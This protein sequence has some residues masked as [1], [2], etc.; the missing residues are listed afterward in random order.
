ME[1]RLLTNSDYPQ[2]IPSKASTV[3]QYLVI[4]LAPSYPYIEGADSKSLK[5]RARMECDTMKTEH[6]SNADILSQR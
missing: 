2:R 3:I 4:P 6:R 1:E 5:N